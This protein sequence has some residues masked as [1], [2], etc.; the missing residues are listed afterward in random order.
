METFKTP[1]EAEFKQRCDALIKEKSAMAHYVEHMCPCLKRMADE[2]LVRIGAE[3]QFRICEASY[4]DR[5]PAFTR[6]E[7][8]MSEKE[9][10][11]WFL[12]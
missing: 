8:T 6:T 12:G 9:R 3:L 2:K 10:I 1:S 5:L 7:M 4:F 11:A